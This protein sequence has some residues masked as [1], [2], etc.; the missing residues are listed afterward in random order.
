V[1]TSK[2]G[3]LIIWQFVTN[4]GKDDKDGNN[5][6]LPPII[7]QDKVISNVCNIENIKTLLSSESLS[8]SKKSQLTSAKWLSS[9]SLAVSMKCGRV[10]LLD[11]SNLDAP[12]AK[13]IYS[14]QY[15]PIWAL[16]VINEKSL[17]ISSDSGEVLNLVANDDGVWSSSVVS[18][19]TRESGM[20]VHYNQ[21]SNLLICGF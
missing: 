15:N 3:Q 20:C 6:I 19:A 1:T 13:T 5:F 14:C 12:T 18:K 7:S 8:S 17:V 2:D 9:T 21:S 10:V 4:N 16:D 11:I